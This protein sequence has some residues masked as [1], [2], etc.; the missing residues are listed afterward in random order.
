MVVVVKYIIIIS[1]KAIA[2]WLEHK[3]WS[4]KLTIKLSKEQLNPFGG[5]IALGHPI[6]ASGARILVTLINGLQN[7]RGKYGIAS[8]CIGGGEASSML[9]QAWNS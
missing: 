8:I 5:A 6:G 7:K 9:I 4:L 3:R 1:A 2:T